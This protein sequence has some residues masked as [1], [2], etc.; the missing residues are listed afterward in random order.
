MKFLYKLLHVTRSELYAKFG[1][2]YYH[3]WLAHLGPIRRWIE[4]NW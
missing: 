3:A 1:R 4:I 2:H